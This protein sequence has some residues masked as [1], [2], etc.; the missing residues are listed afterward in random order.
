MR[1]PM[2]KIIGWIAI[3]LGVLL[4]VVAIGVRAGINSAGVALFGLGFIIA[5]AISARISF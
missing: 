1:G 4:I 2:P 5:G 3:A